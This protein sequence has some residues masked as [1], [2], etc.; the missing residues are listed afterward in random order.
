MPTNDAA[1]Q[2]A[3]NAAEAADDRRGEG[4]DAEEAH[5]DVDHRHR[6]QQDTGHAAT[7]ALIAQISENTYGRGMPM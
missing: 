2:R 4:F 7:P 6:R 3:G 5:V 1:D